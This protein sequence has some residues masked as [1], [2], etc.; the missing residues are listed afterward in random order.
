MKSGTGSN[1]R[2][3]SCWWV[4]GLRFIMNFPLIQSSVVLRQ[5]TDTTGIIATDPDPFLPPQLDEASQAPPADQRTYFPRLP[6]GDTIDVMS[7]R[8]GRVE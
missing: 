5:A 6:Q 3:A 2:A 4:M 7:R 1:S 8:L